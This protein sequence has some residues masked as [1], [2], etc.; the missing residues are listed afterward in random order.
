M[1][2][3]YPQQSD[4]KHRCCR[5]TAYIPSSHY[6]SDEDYNEHLVALKRAWNEIVNADL[7]SNQ[8]RKELRSIHIVRTAAVSDMGIIGP[9]VRL[10]PPIPSAPF[11]PICACTQPASPS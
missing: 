6:H 10:R 4:T 1:F 2:L 3:L 9:K 7:K 11:L 5:I 8:S